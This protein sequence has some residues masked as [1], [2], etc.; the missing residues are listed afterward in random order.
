MALAGSI[1]ALR[2][3]ND[4]IVKLIITFY[5]LDCSVF[6]ACK[7]WIGKIYFESVIISKVTGWIIKDKKV[8][9]GP[10]NVET[11]IETIQFIDAS[12]NWIDIVNVT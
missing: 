8:A 9:V 10:L 5:N 3:S 7:C 4:D 12:R 6:H 11:L 2:M 1:L